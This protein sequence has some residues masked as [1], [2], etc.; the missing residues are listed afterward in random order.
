[1]LLLALSGPVSEL[2]FGNLSHASVIAL[3]A[4]AVFFGDVSAA[5]G[6]LVQG[7]RRVA[8]LAKISIFGALYGTIF[9]IVIIYF[10]GERG[11]VPSLV[12]VAAMGIVTSWW[13]ARKIKVERTFLPW[14]EFSAESSELLK[15]GLVFMASGLMVMGAGY[16]NRIIVLHQLGI[17]AA[18][19]YQA[20]WTLGGLYVGFI[21]QA[22][23]ADFYPR[24]T[25]AANDHPVCWPP[26]HC[27]RWSYR[28]SI[29][30]S[31]RLRWNCCVG[32]P[33]ECFCGSSPGPWVS[34]YWRK[35]SANC[36]FGANSCF[37]RRSWAWSGLVS[38]GMASRVWALP[39]LPRT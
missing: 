6:A 36:S 15:L 32:F 39:S 9:S 5:Q 8:D 14:R 11:I 21:L 19:F 1:M 16:V 27:H 23:G 17:D 10:F 34:S 38:V 33:W 3:L 4:L 29:R 22:M 28:Y 26:S 2:S 30:R 24:L 18:G 35:G 20:A 37:I 25:A 31:L 13:Y 7:M 12:A